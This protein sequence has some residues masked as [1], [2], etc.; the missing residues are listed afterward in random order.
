M[1]KISPNSRRG[2]RLALTAA[3]SGRE[4]GGRAATMRITATGP[5]ERDLA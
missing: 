1:A 3:F 4:P 2:R 5:P